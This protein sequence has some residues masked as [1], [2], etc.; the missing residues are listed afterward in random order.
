MMPNIKWD[1]E[2]DVII[3]GYGLAGGVAAIEACD[4]GAKVIILEKSAYPGGCSIL[5]GG[6]VLCAYDA[7]EATQYLRATSGE[8]IDDGLIQDFAREMAL[9]EKYLRKLASPYHA[10]INTT[11]AH[12]SGA[13][14]EADY[15]P[16]AYPFPGY[17]TFY[18]AGI[19]EV[20]GF[21]GFNWVQRLRPA[22]IN[23]M[24]V[25]FDSVEARPAKVLFSTPAKKLVTSSK[26]E[27]IG[28]IAHQGEKELA[29]KARRA[30]ILA[31]G[32]FEQN[33]WLLKQYLQGTPFYSMAPTTHTGDGILMTQ[34]VGAALWH[35]WHVHGSYG[36]K[37][38]GFPIA[39]RTTFAG[40]RNP[41]RIMPW[42]VTDK[43]GNRYMN[44]YQPAPQDT[45]HR[46][47]ETF[48]PDM[49]GY[50]RIPSYV[51][52]DEEGRKHGPLGQP[53]AIGEAVYEWSR[54][55]QKEVA[56]GWIFKEDSIGKLALRIKETKDNEGVMDPNTLEATISQWNRIATNGKDPLQRPPKT[57]IPIKVSPFYAAPVWPII[58]NTQGGPQ[59]NVRQ[60]V[61]DSFGEPIP[62][63]YT[64]G[65]LGSFWSHIYLL[66]GNLG[67]CL[68]SG[69]VA[70]RNASAEPT[71][72]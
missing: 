5:S 39:F 30:V 68:S 35:M 3:A 8:R 59:H 32:G 52:F 50:S 71:Q 20:P 60:Q 22:G 26:G 70:S 24:K 31:C 27:I 69:R 57:M 14:Y 53:L 18:R 23:L 49:P 67:E 25:V 44:E 42:I 34:K 6:M 16:L 43:F 17:E 28:I 29:L 63:L 55:N 64:A 62:R 1:E 40:S 10:K 66:S 48:D 54:D 9:N 61:L 11:K 13:K 47:M 4:A 58:S 51:I 46:A 12:E 38:D 7:E 36:F 2:T 37:Y 65:E 33:E 41:K 56:K 45:N 15:I 19:A 21:N 72:E